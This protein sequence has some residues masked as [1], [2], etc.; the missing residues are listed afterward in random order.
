[1]KIFSKLLRLDLLV[2]LLVLLISSSTSAYMFKDILIKNAESIVSLEG[3]KTGEQKFSILSGAKC[4]GSF[5]YDLKISRETSDI[6]FKGELN[7]SAFENH[8]NPKV[9]GSVT[10]NN[11]GQLGTSIMTIDMQDIKITAGTLGIRKM[12]ATIKSMVKNETK[13]TKVQLIAGPFILSSDKKGLYKISGPIP[14]QWNPAPKNIYFLRMLQSFGLT[15]SPIS[16][17]Q[18]SCDMEARES[19]D[20][21]QI[22]KRLNSFL[23]L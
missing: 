18:T 5:S 7:I 22:L 3:L 17:V 4:V 9:D 1:M 8:F 16:D 2:A 15:L 6:E 23:R 21:T 14:N 13:H 10:F 19:L 11:L 12:S 20:V